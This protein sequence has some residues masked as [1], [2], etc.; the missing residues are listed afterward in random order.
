MNALETILIEGEMDERAILRSLLESL[1]PGDVALDVGAY[2][3]LH[4]VFMAKKVGHQGKVIAF[5]PDPRNFKTLEANI[6]LNELSQILSV[7]LALGDRLEDKP[8][9][10]SR[11]MT[12]ASNSL[13]QTEG[14]DPSQSV[15]VIPGDD[16]LSREG[17]PSP[18]VVKIDVE[19]YEYPVLKGLSRTLRQE[20]VRRVCCE[21]H[22]PLFPPGTTPALILDL[23]KSLGFDKIETA[24]R[25]G[26]LQ[27][28]C[29]RLN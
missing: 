8:L 14:S 5:E 10:H 29:S 4:S 18:N 13:I 12:G 6:R 28:V 26:Q 7:P 21:I 9:F 27:A 16:F 24:T 1:Q 2:Q 22:S 17:L 23:L 3:G 20:T 19:G 11:R 15:R 25:G